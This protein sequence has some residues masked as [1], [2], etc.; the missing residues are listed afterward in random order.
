MAYEAEYDVV[1]V[2]GGHNG[3]TSACYLAAEGKRVIVVEALESLGGMCSS[4]AFIP[5]APEHTIH[6]CSLDLMSLRVHPMMPQELQ[7]QRHGFRQEEVNPGYVYCHPDG[8]TLVFGRSPEQTAKE[9]RRYS[10]SDADAFLQLMKA[11]YAFIDMAVPQMRV[12]PACFNLG[13]KLKSLAVL[14]KNRHLKPEI[15][16]LI[17][18]PAYSSIME[19]FEHPVIQSALCALLGAAGPITAEATGVYFALLGFLHKYGIGRAIGGMQSIAD[20]LEARLKELGGEVRVSTR[21]EEIVSHNKTIRGVRL[22]DG[23]LLKAKAVISSIHPK[24]ALEMVSTGEL[25]RGTLTK[26]ALAPANAH[27]ASPLKV[28]LALSGQVDYRKLEEQRPDNLSL[29][30][31]VLLIG[32]VE[33][34]LDNFRCA[35]R[36]EV[37]P[38]PYLWMTAP[39]AM[40]PS[41]APEG[42]DVA[43]LYPVA[44]PVKP[45]EGWDQIRATVA[46]QV[47]DQ[48]AE[49]MNGLK[50]YEIG[51]RIEAAPDLASRLSVH[52]GCVVHIDTATTRSGTMRPASGLGGDTLPVSGLFLGGAGSHPGGGVNGMPGRIAAGRVKRF[53]K[54]IS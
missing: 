1:I 45:K 2:G 52:N 4:G 5:E 16:A 11:V 19:R 43:Y 29:R 42:Q 13:A 12:D 10:D 32:T 33:G 24:H 44:M 38:K 15:M 8:N 47:I 46:Q 7:L 20:A 25:D 14:L 22:A 35:A 21:V 48:A 50:K 30:R 27:G 26:V 9:I 53:L 54:K 17:S 28:D 51:R 34:V 23:S 49:Y 3:L 40:D 37:S 6:P 18:S 31:S 39:T 36:G 41:Q